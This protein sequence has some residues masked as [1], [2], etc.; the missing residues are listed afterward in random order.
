MKQALVYDP[1]FLKHG[2]PD[3]PENFHRLEALLEAVANHAG[4]APDFISPAPID[5]EAVLSV[6][7]PSHLEHLEAFCRAGGGWLDQDTFAGPDSLEI[8]FLAAGAALGAWESL[9]AGYNHSFA[10]VRP[11][12]HHATPT[13]SMGFCLLNNLAILAAWLLREGAAQR[14]L[15]IDWDAHHGNGTQEIF[16]SD[17]RVLYFSSHQWPLFPGTGAL[18]ETGAGAGE[19]FNLNCPLPPGS[20]DA[21]FLYAYQQLLLPVARRF[22]PQVVLVSAGFDA[23][24]ADPLSHLRVSAAGFG[25]LARLVRH[26]A[27]G[28]LAGGKVVSVLEGGYDLPALADSVL[29]VLEAWEEPAP[30]PPPAVPIKVVNHHV[31]S[32]V[33]RI[34]TVH[35][36][37]FD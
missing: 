32:R 17:P 27:D 10:L 9:E 22:D 25:N 1:L 18:E 33:E 5:R 12:G 23:H 34:K 11:P 4:T 21:E 35:S 36:R 19:G 37:W 28:S 20:G 24:Q 3:H 2:P 6:H 31:V 14:I 15:V 8:A 29:A 7:H 30:A 13:R 16:Y 26:L